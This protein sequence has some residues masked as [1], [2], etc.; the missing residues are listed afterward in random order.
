MDLDKLSYRLD[1]KNKI[2]TKIL[3][4]F[5]SLKTQININ[6][7]FYSKLNQRKINVITSTNNYEFIFSKYLNLQ[8]DQHIASIKD[9]LS[10]IKIKK[11]QYQTLKTL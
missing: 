6:L 10:S 11:T 1:K 5:Y 9:F 4:R 2:A 8:E 7:D 3:A